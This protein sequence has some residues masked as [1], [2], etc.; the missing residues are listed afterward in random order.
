MQSG[1]IVAVRAVVMLACMIVVPLV[2][3]FWKHWPQAIDLARGGRWTELA[4]L[5]ADIVTK[6]GPQPT[7]THVGTQEAP[8]FGDNRVENAASIGAVDAPPT[9]HANP[10]ASSAP[11]PPAMVIG[12]VTPA[13]MTAPTGT[14]APVA[15]PAAHQVPT[16]DVPPSQPNGSPIPDPAATAASLPASMAP[17]TPLDAAP[18]AEGS[19]QSNPF[20]D[21]EQRLRSLGATYYL[22]ESWGTEGNLYR[23]HVKMAMA[24]NPNYNRHFEATDA[25]PL[26]AMSR[27]LE[28]VEMWRSGRQP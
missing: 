18:H 27:V 9:I 12:D 10:F 28:D 21:L 1:P 20:R 17:Q 5:G 4:E 16:T 13:S 26:I 25:D 11:A 6:S 23:F 7:T 24:G 19:P 14:A 22:L 3:I 2:A 15:A 8:T